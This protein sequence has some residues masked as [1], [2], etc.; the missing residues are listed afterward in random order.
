MDRVEV[1]VTS[2]L[3][4]QVAIVQRELSATLQQQME[5]AQEELSSTLQ[6][7]MAAGAT[8]GATAPK[9]AGAAAV[10]ELRAAVEAS[11][12]A[13][14]SGL[15]VLSRR[16]DGLKAQLTQQA[17]R[18]GAGGALPEWH[19]EPFAPD[20]TCIIPLLTPQRCSSAI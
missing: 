4:G 14:G 9:G 10:E 13:L 20:A 12:Q 18:G 6:R 3:R 16:A 2:T 17:G 1:E 11:R 5:S 15:Q 7:H 19:F 8:A